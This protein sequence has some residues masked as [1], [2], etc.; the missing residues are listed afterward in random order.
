MGQQQHPKKSFFVQKQNF[1]VVSTQQVSTK[2]FTANR[3]YVGSAMGMSL[4]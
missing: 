3:N 1:A 4:V 2:L